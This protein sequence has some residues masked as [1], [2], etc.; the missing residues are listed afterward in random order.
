MFQTVIFQLFLSSW[1][2]LFQPQPIVNLKAK[3][4]YK[5]QTAPPEKSLNL[6]LNNTWFGY[7]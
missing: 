5:N 1:L 4:T 3:H 6:L 2:M 7:W